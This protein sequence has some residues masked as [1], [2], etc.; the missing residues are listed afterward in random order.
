MSNK[1][2]LFT[3]LHKVD[4][5][6]TPETTTETKF[7]WCEFKGGL[8][9]NII[10][11]NCEFIESDFYFCHFINVQFINCSFKGKFFYCFIEECLYQDCILDIC[12]KSSEILKTSFN[13]CN[14]SKWQQRET[15]L[16]KVEINSNCVFDWKDRVL[17]RY[18]IQK[19]LQYP[20][21][22]DESDLIAIIGYGYRCHKDFEHFQHPLRS[23][24]ILA[25]SKYIKAS[26]LTPKYLKEE[27]KKIENLNERPI[28]N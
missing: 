1:V 15:D 18:L 2:S 25:L 23:K 11:E 8:F 21:T 3:K 20:L 24:I 10:F 14:L 17:I 19:E 26:P 12:M 28:T 5:L 9:D 27:L 6:L 7:S 16:F 22:L 4:L 13:S